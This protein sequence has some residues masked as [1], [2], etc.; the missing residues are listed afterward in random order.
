VR[1]YA[2]PGFEPVLDAFAAN[3]DRRGEVGA[4]FAAYVDGELV[5]DLWGGVADTETGAP[6]ERDTLQLIFSGTKGV[7]ATALLI[8]ADRGQLDFEEPVATY[9]PE[10]AQ[11]GK[12]SITVG[13]VL[14]HQSGL[15]ALDA[16]VSAEAILDGEAMAELLA[17]QPPQWSGERRVSYH[18]LT[19]GWLCGE[20]VRRIA[21]TTVGALV[22]TEIAEPL[23]AE[24]WI[25]LP[26]EL[27]GRVTTLCTRADFRTLIAAASAGPGERRATNPPI[28]DEPL[29]WNLPAVH[30]AEI[31]GANGIASARGMATLYGCLACGGTLGGTRLLC[32]DVVERGRA[33][34][35][36]GLDALSDESLAFGLGFQLQTEGAPFGPPVDGYGHAGAGGSVHGAWPRLRAGFSYVMSQMR[37]DTDDDRSRTLLAALYVAAANR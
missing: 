18:S 9:W 13:D 20:L 31:P 25:G 32:E 11:S 15:P 23:D 33:E 19:Y 36:R 4:A 7:V 10:F 2:A 6:W 21:G 26:P 22:R 1:G 5:V 28:F 8:L 34:R 24:V 12:A 35:A 27:E 3:L 30:A 37:D 29:L 14:S 17:R 16:D